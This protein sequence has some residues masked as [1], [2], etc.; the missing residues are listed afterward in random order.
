MTKTGRPIKTSLQP[1]SYATLL[2][3]TLAQPAGFNGL[4]C[5]ALPAETR[6]ESL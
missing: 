2:M 6:R 4:L 1:I 5:K 3:S